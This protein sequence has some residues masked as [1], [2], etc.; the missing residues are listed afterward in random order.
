MK[1]RRQAKILELIREHEI[2]TQ[3][4]LISKLRENGFEVTQATVSRD[5]KELKLQKTLTADGKYRYV[6]AAKTPQAS[7]RALLPCFRL[8]CSRWIMP[9]I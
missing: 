7:P 6:A 5:I 9:E 4:G 1:S 2:N 8:R 3:E